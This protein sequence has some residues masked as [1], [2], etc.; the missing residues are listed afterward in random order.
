MKKILRA[1]L[2]TLLLMT[3]NVWTGSAHTSASCSV[4]RDSTRNTP[5]TH[6][7]GINARG[8]WLMPTHKFFRGENGTGKPLNY[9]ASAHL[10]Y[11]Y[12]FPASST[13]G[14]LFPTAYQGIGVGWNTFF[15]KKEIGMPTAV[16]IYSREH[17]YADSPAASHLIMNGI[18]AHHSA[19]SHFTTTR[20][21]T[22]DPTSTTPW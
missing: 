20:N 19:G 7:I 12:Q 17:R 3:L 22:A 18:S 4:P 11:S 2:L 14:T 6:R 8:A 15:D 16:Y 1:T 5:S 9:S 10:Q 13:F 21:L